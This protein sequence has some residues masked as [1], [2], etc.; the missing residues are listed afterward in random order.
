M[1][2]RGREAEGAAAG[3]MAVRLTDTRSTDLDDAQAVV[4]DPGAGLPCWLSA[5]VHAALAMRNVRADEPD[6]GAPV[7]PR[8]ARAC[9]SAASTPAGS[10]SRATTMRG[11]LGK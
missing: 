8:L 9:D 6:P 10:R 4:P 11:W 2:G 1:R 7:L 5:D 3:I